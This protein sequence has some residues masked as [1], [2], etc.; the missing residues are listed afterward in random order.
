MED[1]GWRGVAGGK[2]MGG[3]GWRDGR[4]VDDDGG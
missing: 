1:G 4:M 2:L 3:C